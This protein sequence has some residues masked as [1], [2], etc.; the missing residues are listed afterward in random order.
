MTESIGDAMNQS[1]APSTSDSDSTQPR[2]R[3]RFVRSCKDVYSASVSGGADHSSDAPSSSSVSSSVTMAKGNSTP[4][5]RG[6]P[7]NSNVA[8][9][10]SN[11]TPRTPRARKPKPKLEFNQRKI[12]PLPANVMGIIDREVLTRLP[13]REDGDYYVGDIIFVIISGYPYW[14]CMITLD[15]QT[16]RYTKSELSSYLIV[17]AFSFIDFVIASNFHFVMLRHANTL[18]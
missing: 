4:R 3:M 9:E 13:E 5:G 8:G 7:K 10:E 11:T 6:R 15:P 16:N 2:L 12:V 14:P 18:F 1:S 17:G